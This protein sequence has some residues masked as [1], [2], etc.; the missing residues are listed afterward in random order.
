MS[1]FNLNRRAFALTLAAAFAAPS[2]ANA[3]SAQAIDEGRFVSINGVE[4]WIAI[5]GADVRKP[6]M[7]FLQGGPGIGAAFMAPALAAW[8][9]EFTVVYWDQPGGGFT[10][11]KNAGNPGEQTL[12]RYARD[13]IAVAEYALRRLGQRKLVVFGNSWGTQLG[14]EVIHRRPDLVSAYVGASQAVGM[15][16]W[17]RGYELALDAAR[18]RGDVAAVASLERAGPPPYASLEAFMPRQI[19]TNPP[20][21]PAS[22]VETAAT[23]AFNAII[24]SPPAPGASWAAP[25]AP[26]PGYDFGAVFM[27]TATAMIPVWQQMEIRDYGRRFPMPIFVFQGDNDINTPHDLARDWVSEIEAPAKAFELIPGASHNTMPFHEVILS[28][29]RRR[30][31]PVL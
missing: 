23:A 2:I 22:E 11:I 27:R 19:Y 20:G 31:L 17:V 3:Q 26:P 13:A 24:F 4:Q 21:Q 10:D 12:D 28:Q 1:Q 25:I 6:I 9:Q 30:V 29:L 18:A 15:R 8:E 16:G 14:V 5:R 7:L